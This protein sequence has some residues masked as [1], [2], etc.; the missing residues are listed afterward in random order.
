M[1]FTDRIYENDKLSN[2]RRYVFDTGLHSYSWVLNLVD[3]M[4]ITVSK[5]YKP[6]AYDHT[7]A[8]YL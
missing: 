1:I 2:S 6:V 3:W 8:K 5:I 4:K 7:N